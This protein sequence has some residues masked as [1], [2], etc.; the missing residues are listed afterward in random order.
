MAVKLE[1]IGAL[2]ADHLRP[3]LEE[4]SVK[5]SRASG[6]RLEVEKV[7]SGFFPEV[8]GERIIIYLKVARDA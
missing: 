8:A 5:M 6:F 7:T 1:S 4:L 3:T 2:I